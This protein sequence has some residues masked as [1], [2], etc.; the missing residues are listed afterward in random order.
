MIACVRGRRFHN[1]QGQPHRK[2]RTHRYLALNCYV[3]LEATRQRQRY[4]QP[5]TGAGKLT[6]KPG[7]HLEKPLEQLAQRLLVHPDPAVLNIQLQPL[8]VR[9]F[10]CSDDQ[11]NPTL[12][13][14]LECV[15][16][17]VE[18]NLP[19]ARAVGLDPQVFLDRAGD[20]EL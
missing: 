15:V 16:Q 9:M 3:A 17:E 5:Q 20:F 6:R 2:Q 7:F 19:Q 14:E 13:R 12:L 10:N 18:Q 1:G 8:L 11:R 4:V